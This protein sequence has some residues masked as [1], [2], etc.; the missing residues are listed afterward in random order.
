MSNSRDYETTAQCAESAI[1][2]MRDSHNLPTPEHFE[3]WFSYFQGSRPELNDVIDQAV[4]GGE[5]ITDEMLDELYHRF[6]IQD[7]S[8]FVINSTTEEI[9]ATIEQ[10]I[11]LV[12]RAGRDT[13]DFGNELDGASGR[14]DG[15]VDPEVLREI[16]VGLQES[17]RQML[18]RSRRMEVQLS[19]SNQQI[20]ELRTHLVSVRE[21]VMTDGLTGVSNRRHF[22]SVLREFAGRASR[23]GQP[24]TLCMIDIDYFK[25]FNDT[26]GHQ[27]GDEVLK[28]VAKMLKDSTKG[29]D[30]VARYGG[31]EFALLLPSTTLRDATQLADKIRTVVAK[32]N[33][34]KRTTGEYIGSI[35]LSAGVSL[36]RAHEALES[37]VERADLGL[38][39]AKNS[40]RNRVC[41]EL[42][43]ASDVKEAS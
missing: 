40:G 38:Y 36:Y 10:V 43:L 3:L 34:K 12:G 16:A 14:L 20:M 7:S 8:D 37:F 18:E 32:N 9:E 6:F 22:D 25:R 1:A 33:L 27:L 31:E 35:N 21:E 13:R 42:M 30:I 26:H 41:N 17:T 4:E 19:K 11:N 5:D 23:D 39:L 24:L 2:R 15:T 29:S 28:L